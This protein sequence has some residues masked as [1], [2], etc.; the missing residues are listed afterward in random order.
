[1]KKNAHYLGQALPLVN[2]CK[3]LT[4]TFFYDL[5]STESSV[6]FGEAV[7]LPALGDGVQDGRHVLLGALGELVVVV[8]VA[9]RGRR[10]H[11]I[12][13]D[14]TARATFWRVV[15]LKVNGNQ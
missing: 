7:G 5:V 3:S 11:D 13:A 4:L 6:A 2:L 14:F 9:A 10:E 15:V 8:A 1:M 12:V